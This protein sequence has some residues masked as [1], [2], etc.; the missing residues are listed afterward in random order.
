MI[1]IFDSGIGG[2]TVVKEFFRFFPKY[3]IIYFGDNARLPYG[4]KSPHLI[5]K[6]SK[7]IVQWLLDKGAKVIVIA[8]HTASALAAD[9]LRKEFPKI[10]FFDIISPGIKT[11]VQFSQNK[12][13]GIIGTP[14]TIK[15]QIHKK[16][17]LKI[18][19]SLKIY[20]R[21][22]PLFVPLVEEGWV[23][24][25]VTQEIAKIY[26]DPLKKKKIDTLILACTHYP[27][28][29]KTISK[30]MGKKVKII[31]PARDLVGDFKNFLQNNK[32][33]EL[34]L[35][36]NKNHYFFFSD[37]PYNFNR[38]SQLCLRREIN[39]KINSLI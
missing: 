6:W 37:Q 11:A 18:D 20:S 9:F 17:L 39:F 8:C 12:K 32:K 23:E 14:S 4:T 2:L 27:I 31:N 10:I 16:K 30:I 26:L 15:S 13:I 1:G 24:H 21:A 22:C 29:E 3:Q 5:K 28:L 7:E 25:K 35:K 19:S 34:K 33:V 38:L 36:K